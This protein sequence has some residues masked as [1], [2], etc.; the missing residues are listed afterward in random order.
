MF[1][2]IQRMATELV[3]G[4][5]GM[6]CEERLR[7]PGLPCLE[8]RR[9][10]GDLI[11]FCSSLRRGSWEMCWDL[12]PGNRWQDGR[13]TK[14]VSW[15]D[16]DWAVGGIYLP[17]G[18]SNTVMASWQ[19]GWWTFHSIPLNPTPFLSIPYFH[20][21]ICIYTQTHYHEQLTFNVISKQVRLSRIVNMDS[22]GDN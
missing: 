17:W 16:S 19:G 15:G 18:W 20:L 22:P 4:V 7:V 11:A 10:R 3:R 2:S 5:E 14:C 12:L 13:G 8:K 6:S 9:S 21:Y 1:E